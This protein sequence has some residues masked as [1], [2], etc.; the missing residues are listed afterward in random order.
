MLELIPLMFE[1]APML[2]FAGGILVGV[3]VSILA[4]VA[5]MLV[6]WG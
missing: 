4:F 1:P 3:A 6:D 2:I 5:F